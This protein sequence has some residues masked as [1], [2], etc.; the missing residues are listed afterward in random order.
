M[1]SKPHI[2]KEADIS[3]VIDRIKSYARNYPNY[4]SFLVD[5]VGKLD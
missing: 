4:N 5:I 2:F 3:Q 1:K